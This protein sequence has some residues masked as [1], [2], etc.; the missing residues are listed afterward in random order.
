MNTKGVVCS[1]PCECGRVNVGKNG[2]MVK[3]AQEN[4]HEWRRQQ[5]LRDL[6]MKP[7]RSCTI[8]MHRRTVDKRRRA[9]MLEHSFLHGTFPTHRSSPLSS[10]NLPLPISLPYSVVNTMIQYKSLAK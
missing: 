1:I 10:F 3:R 9:K 8:I 2:R 5:M 4:S 7:D 6:D